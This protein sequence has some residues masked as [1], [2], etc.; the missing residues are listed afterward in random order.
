MQIHNVAQGSS[1][2]HALR[3]DCF[4]ASEAPAMMGCGWISREELLA[5]KHSGITPE[6]DNATLA[7]FAKGHAVE[8]LARPIIENRIGEQLFPATAT[9]DEYPWLL[10]SFDGIDMMEV[11][12]FEHKLWNPSLA[13]AVLAKELPPKYFWQL[14]QQ[15]A[16]SGAEKAIFVVSDG[17]EE[18]MVSMEYFP[19]P[20]RKEQ[21]IAGWEQ[22]KKDLE[23]YQPQESKAMPS[24]NV[25][26]DLPVVT[27]RMN[28]MA[29]ASDFDVYRNQAAIMLERARRP[30]LEDQDF[31]DGK[32]LVTVFEKAEKHLKSRADEVIA[33][34]VDIN[35]F[36]AD[37]LAM[38]EEFKKT[39]LD[40]GKRV[41]TELNARKLKIQNTAKQKIS[42]FV[43]ALE[44][45][46]SGIRLQKVDDGIVAAVKGK[47]NL[48]NYQGAANDAVAAAKIAYRQQAELIHANLR[49]LDENAGEYRFLF[50]DLQSIAFKSSDDFSN[51]LNARISQHKAAEAAKL[52]AERERIR[53][54]EEAKA[55]AEIER[56]Q[57][58]R[59]ANECKAEEAEQKPVLA[60]HEVIQ[61]VAPGT[62]SSIA[63]TEPVRMTT[64]FGGAS[65]TQS[66]ITVTISSELVKRLQNLASIECPL[67][68]LAI[69]CLEDMGLEVPEMA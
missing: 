57:R 1:E 65:K 12:V 31:A 34:A 19:V 4:T 64:G 51:L 46:L 23:S 53:K 3:A 49:A 63:K 33:Q 60:P 35:Q 29:V 44:S 11:I 36:R 25:I 39:R 13:D 37:L 62:I 38:A 58:I 2:W 6:F 17:T 50:A 15:L 14:E 67:Q 22:F 32:K 59:E 42:E 40:L 24:A 9:S 5:Q 26:N 48:Q 10:A 68:K 21:L 8:E 7:R 55:R 47:S 28:G 43:A 18:N 54:E 16:V 20:G 41:E 45:G 66:R 56:K 61:V 69:E 52:E 30:M 27:Y